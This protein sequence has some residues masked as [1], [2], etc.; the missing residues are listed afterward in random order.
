MSVRCQIY[1]KD[2]KSFKSALL[3]EAEVHR[4]FGKR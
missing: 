2:W 1:I 3:E 4:R